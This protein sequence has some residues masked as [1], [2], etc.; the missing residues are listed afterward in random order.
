MKVG[1][2]DPAKL[3]DLVLHRLPVLSDDIVCGPATGLDCAAIRFK[4]GLEV[5]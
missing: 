4:D 1:K 3:E 5:L 2:L